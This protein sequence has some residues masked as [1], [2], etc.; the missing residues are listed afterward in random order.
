MPWSKPRD[1]QQRWL[2]GWSMMCKDKR[3]QFV[4]SREKKAKEEGLLAVSNHV[5]GAGR[6]CG[7]T[8]L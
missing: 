2:V 6:Q 5:M 4:Q 7:F 1:K 3:A 8:L